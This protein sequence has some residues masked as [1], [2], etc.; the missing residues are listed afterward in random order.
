MQPNNF[1]KKIRE[2]LTN[3][4]FAYDPAAWEQAAAMLER[5]KR[6]K[7]A[8]WWFWSVAGIL[9]LGVVGAVQYTPWS[10]TAKPNA[11][12]ASNHS[13]QKPQKTIQNTLDVPAESKTSTFAETPTL[14]TPAAGSPTSP[15]HA[16]SSSKISFTPPQASPSNTVLLADKQEYSPELDIMLAKVPG[17]FQ[18]I[19]F[20]TSIQQKEGAESN[21]SFER[22]KPNSQ[23]FTLG[24]HAFGGS[25]LQSIE[26]NRQLN[27][28][29]GVFV[30]IRKNKFYFALEPALQYVQGPTGSSSRNDTSYAFGQI[31]KTQ[32]L[33]WNNL[34]LFQ[35]PVLI[36][37][38]IYPKHTLSA[39]VVAQQY[40]QSSYTLSETS[41]TQGFPSQIGSELSGNARI[42]ELI[43][44]QV[45]GLL[46]YQYQI[47][48]AFSLGLQYNLSG[49]PAP[50]VVQSQMQLQL[51]YHLFNRST[52]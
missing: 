13:E 32:N 33:V 42:S 16:S 52:Q 28:G 15:T 8:F 6:K 41:F 10:S 24:L 4:H 19:L 26:T 51:K 12:T 49:L 9:L 11:V 25:A 44:P 14:N 29:G 50:S 18:R 45:Y 17:R 23:S 22:K 20:A 39:G 7:R 48:P 46:R 27:Y 3:K 43:L 34:L 2:V 36:G 38:E 35:V 30:E 47:R 31:I 37:I 5:Q 21:R 40:L 1:D